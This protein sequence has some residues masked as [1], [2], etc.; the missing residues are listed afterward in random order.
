MTPDERL[1][2]DERLKGPREK[3]DPTRFEA[4]WSQGRAMTMESAI[5]L[6]LETDPGTPDEPARR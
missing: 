6:A 5:A 2:F 3:L 4:I 1:Y